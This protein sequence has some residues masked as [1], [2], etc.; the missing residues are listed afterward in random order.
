MNYSC[1]LPCIWEANGAGEGDEY[2][3]VSYLVYL[4]LPGQGSECSRSAQ[5]HEA[6]VTQTD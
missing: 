6:P 2:S 5:G 1:R 4:R 3:D